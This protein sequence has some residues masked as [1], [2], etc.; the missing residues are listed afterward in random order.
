MLTAIENPRMGRSKQAD[1]GETRPALPDKKKRKT[2]PL[3]VKAELHEKIAVI[4]ARRGIEISEF[5][6][7]I[8]RP[9]VLAEY[10]RVV[11]EMA[12]EVPKD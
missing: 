10:A 11:R 6:D 1:E 7:P 3:T 5:V 9:V 8:L 4:C 12:A 2:A